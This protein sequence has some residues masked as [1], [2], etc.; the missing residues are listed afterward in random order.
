MQVLPIKIEF[1]SN[2]KFFLE[3]VVLI[4]PHNVNL[5]QVLLTLSLYESGKSKS[6]L[7]IKMSRS[8]EHILT[9]IFKTFMKAYVLEFY[10]V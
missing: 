9:N 8:L 10:S 4:T 1:G 7:A 5:L 6:D 2:P 3:V